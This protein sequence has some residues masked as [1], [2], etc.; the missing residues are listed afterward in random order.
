MRHRCIPLLTTALA[1][2]PAAAGPYDE[3]YVLFVPA[4]RSETQ[5]IRP[6]VVV[7]ID[8]KPVGLRRAEPVAPGLHQVEV[9]LPSAK[10]MSNPGRDTLT[11]TAEPCTRYYLGARRSTRTSRD[12]TAFVERTETIGECRRSRQ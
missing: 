10:G 8:G 4:A 9:S 7:A 3:P 1:A 6:A 11:I 12:W 2:L 5:D